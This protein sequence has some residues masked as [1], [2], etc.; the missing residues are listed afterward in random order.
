MKPYLIETSSRVR[1]VSLFL[2]LLLLFASYR[3][4]VCLLSMSSLRSSSNDGS[5]LFPNQNKPPPTRQ[6]SRAT[7][8][9]LSL[10]RSSN[11]LPSA[12]P[13]SIRNGQAPAVGNPPPSP[14]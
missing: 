6:Q 14:T 5:P 8:E 3:P 9:R 1:G 4:A 12:E 13:R 10:Q 7:I 2:V 11:V